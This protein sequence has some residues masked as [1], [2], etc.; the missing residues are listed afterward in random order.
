MVISIIG[1]LAA[2]S[3]VSFT[4]S[5]KQARDTSRKSDI[6]QYQS[7]LELYANKNSLYPSRPVAS[8]VLA[9]QTLCSDLSLSNCPEDTKNAL[10]SSFAYRYQSD[11]TVSDGSATATKYV[12]WAKLE[13]SSVYFIVCSNG[14]VGTMAQ[15]LFGVAGGACPI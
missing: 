2:L 15:S 3:I 13:N 6:K 11:G 10:D 4:S 7:S 1:I 5:Q 8:G 9:S 12:L 14:K